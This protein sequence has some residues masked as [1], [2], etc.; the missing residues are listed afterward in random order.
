MFSIQGVPRLKKS[1][2]FI[3]LPVNDYLVIKSSEDTCVWSVT[4]FFAFISVQGYSTLGLVI[5]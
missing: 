1:N 2:L 5:I 3:K 4:K